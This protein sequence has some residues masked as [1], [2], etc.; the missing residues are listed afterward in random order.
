[1]ARVLLGTPDVDKVMAMPL[2]DSFQYV[3]YQV[4][5]RKA[6]D[7]RLAFTVAVEGASDLTQI[8]TAQWG[9]RYLLKY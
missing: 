9:D 3:R 5:P 8:P 7:M 6:E 2:E 1:M 4:E